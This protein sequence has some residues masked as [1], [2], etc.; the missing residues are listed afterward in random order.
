M[1]NFL[2]SKLKK[3]TE[4]F[5][6]FSIG[7]KIKSLFSKPFDENLFNNLEKLFYESDLGISISTELT[8]KLKKILKKEPNLKIEDILKILKEDL[9]KYTVSIEEKPQNS[10]HVIMIVGVNGGGKTTSIAKLANFY[11]NDKKKVLLIAADTYRAAAI[12]QLDI[13]AKKI[14]VEIVKSSQGHDPS[15]VV[16][17]GLNKAKAKNFDIVI[18]DTSGRL[19]TKTDLMQELNKIKKVSTKVLERD[20]DETILIIDATTGQNALDQA[21]N[22]NNYTKISSIF[23]TKLDG[24]A[25]GGIIINIQKELQIP[26]KWIGLGEKIED[27]SIFDT[28][29]FIDQ[30]LSLD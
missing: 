16:F 10:P 12:D 17:D 9:K 23:L 30:L 3:F 15:S 29:N 26:I 1:F 19:H 8:E 21:K 28:E 13:W 2:K 5:K 27:I 14:D 4:F 7:K 6:K 25:K 24:S 22:F 11:K 20:I 18:I